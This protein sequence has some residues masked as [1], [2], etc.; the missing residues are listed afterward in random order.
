MENGLYSHLSGDSTI[1]DIVGTNIYGGQV[2]QHATAPFV[3][4]FR[5][6][7]YRVHSTLGPNGLANPRMQIDCYASTY[8][9]VKELA[10]AVRKSVNGF[11]GAMGSVNIGGSRLVSE[12]DSFDNDEQI[13]R[14]SMDFSFWF[15]EATS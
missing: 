4:F 13:Y 9:G 8:Q 10:D 15:T 1:T 6:G 11:R 5:V 3:R 2:A 7:A 14:I 12:F